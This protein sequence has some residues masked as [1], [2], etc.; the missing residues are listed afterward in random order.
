MRTQI[1][2]AARGRI[3]SAMRSAAASENV[4]AEKV[5]LEVASGRAVIPANPLH[6]GLKPAVV[7]RA[8][9][10]KINANIGCSA[11]ASDRTKE[12]EKLRVA[13]DAGADCVM[14][15]SV[16]TGLVRMRK[17]MLAACPVALGT[18][19]IYEAVARV[20]GDATKLDGDILLAVIEDH[21]R[22]GV[23][24]MTLHSGLLQSH[25]PIAVKRIMGIVSRGGAIL[26][27]WMVCHRKENPLY[28]RWDEVMDICH[29]YDVTVSLG[30]GLRPGCLADASD[31]AQFAELSVLGKLVRRCRARGVQV[32]VEGPG[33]VPFNQIEMNMKREENVCHGA[34]FYVLGPVVTDIAPGYDH[35]T[36]C[37]GA[38]AAAYHGAAL[39]CYVTAAEHLALPTADEVRGGIVAYRIAA[40]AADVARGLPG[41]RDADDAMARARMDFNWERQFELAIDGKH[42][43]ARFMKTMTA[44]DKNTDHCSM[45]GKDFCAVRRTKRLHEASH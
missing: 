3:T 26:A 21:A 11:T 23:D 27:E 29:R 34:P 22:Q 36:S 42:A 38:T 1:E 37:I 43:R 15:L 16:G 35:I 39:L 25:V 30:D 9:R 6:K 2:E 32:M 31:K 28:T 45:C 4:P 10:T 17:A 18:V 19:P 20:R 5:R 14:D 8:F 13:L 41:A 7:G 44:R 40:H 33:H 12:L 24:F